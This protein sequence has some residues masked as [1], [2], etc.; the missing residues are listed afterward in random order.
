MSRR[1]AFRQAKRDAGIPN[2]QSPTVEREYL[3]DGYG[4]MV[5]NSKG[6]VV[7]T[8]DYYFTNNKGKKIIIQKHSIGHSKAVPLR[9]ADPHFNVRPIDRPMTGNVR[10]THGH[11]NFN[12][13][14]K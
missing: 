6:A 3:K 11:Y 4:N 10:G 1:D 13:E 7:K 12:W 2:T 5:K 14:L 9:G 8:R